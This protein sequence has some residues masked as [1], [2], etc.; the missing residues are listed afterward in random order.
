MTVS[1]L[2]VL[3]SQDLPTLRRTGNGTS[4]GMEREYRAHRRAVDLKMALVQM[5]AL[6]SHSYIS[7]QRE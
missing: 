3:N 1:R 2:E 6:R 7:S 4:A 5:M